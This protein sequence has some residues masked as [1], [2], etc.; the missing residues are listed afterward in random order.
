M[1][2]QKATNTMKM[3]FPLMPD[4][5]KRYYLEGGHDSIYMEEHMTGTETVFITF[6]DHGKREDRKDMRLP[7]VVENLDPPM[8][9]IHDLYHPYH[10]YPHHTFPLW[11]DFLVQWDHQYLLQETLCRREDPFFQLNSME[12]TI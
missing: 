4:C 11:F 1:H 7:G 5:Y 9:F 2:M 12:M 6:L 3:Y 8:I 10:L